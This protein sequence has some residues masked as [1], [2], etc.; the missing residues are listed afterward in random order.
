MRVALGAD[1]AGLPLIEPIR[2]LLKAKGVA[3]V[4]FTPAPGQ[5]VDY[6]DYAKKV[7]EALLSGQADR[8]VLVCGSGVGMA[9]AANR[10]KGIRAVCAGEAYTAKM[11]R[12]HNDC[13]VLCMGARIIGPG[14]A[15]TLVDVFLSTEFEGGR[16]AARVAK[17]EA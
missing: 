9:I 14:V 1:H 11:S 2:E 13:N 8:G 6:P 15:E 10:H 7:A 4:D 17:L 12:L 5:K 16:H 3:V